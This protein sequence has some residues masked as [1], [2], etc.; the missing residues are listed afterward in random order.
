MYHSHVAESRF[1]ASGMYGA[2]VVLEPGATWDPARDHL[3]IFSQWGVITPAWDA[4]IVLNAKREP[5]FGPL[6]EGIAHRLRI[7]NI[8]AGDMVELD[9]LQGDSVISA[10]K[11]AKDGM[12]LAPNQAVTVPARFELGE[13]ETMDVEIRPRPGDLKIS[14]RSFNNFEVRI[15]VR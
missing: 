3:L 11:L 10:R 13:G 1:L 4:P 5:A 7:I 6:K 12:D 15:P 2:L 14:V 9:M 8:A